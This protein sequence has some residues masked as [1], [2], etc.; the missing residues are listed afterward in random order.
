MID[1]NHIRTGRIVSLH[2]NL[3]LSPQFQGSA[4]LEN[5]GT[6]PAFMRSH[7]LS[8]D[9]DF[10]AS[11]YSFKTQEYTF[12]RQLISEKLF[13]SVITYTFV[14]C[15]SFHL[16]IFRIPGMGNCHFLPLAVPL[17]G[18]THRVRRKRPFL[19]L[20]ASIERNDITCGRIIHNCSQ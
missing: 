8:V 17:C 13:L 2:D 18:S 4:Y 16:H 11:P 9:I 19:K 10:C 20:P 3:V 6:I 1:R 7:Q 15:I 12:T 5:E 14:E